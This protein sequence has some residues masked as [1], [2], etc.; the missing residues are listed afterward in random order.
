MQSSDIDSAIRA[1]SEKER[2]GLLSRLYHGDLLV[3][4]ELRRRVRESVAERTRVE[5]PKARTVGELRARA[6]EI[7]AARE[8]AAEAAVLAERERRE[9][10]AAEAR[11]KRLAA[12]AARGEAAWRE[13]DTDIERRN[14]TGYD[15]AKSLL[16]DLRDVASSQ[17]RMNEFEQR[18]GALRQKHA[19]KA[20]FIDRLRS[21]SQ[22]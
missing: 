5:P 2:L 12:L 18:L 22:S 1:L 19:R 11:K 9:A 13:V 14:A 8:R 17:G 4:V 3:G 10:E 7:A 15:R 20:Q 16:A 21:L 6:G